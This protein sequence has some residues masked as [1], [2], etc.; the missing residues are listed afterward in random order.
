MNDWA[1]NAIGKIRQ[2]QENERL[3][4]AKLAE[5]QR[6]RKAHGTL[7]W[8]QVRAKVRALVAALKEKSGG[9]DILVIQNDQPT[10]M[11]VRN[12]VGGGQLLHMAFDLETTKLSWTCGD[13]ARDGW[14]ISVTETG[15]AEFVWG[16]GIPASID[17]IATQMLEALLEI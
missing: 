10:E 4:A 15:G 17:S 8:D 11:V 5:Q 12:Q 14:E 3:K 13:E 6:I 1:E 7:R 2:K 9:T 16:R